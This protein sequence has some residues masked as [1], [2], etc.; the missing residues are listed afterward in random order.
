MFEEVFVR[1]KICLFDIIS[2]KV[3]VCRCHWKWPLCIITFIRRMATLNKY[4]KVRIQTDYMK[5]KEREIKIQKC[6][7]D[8]KMSKNKR[9][10]EEEIE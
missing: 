2:S 8:E 1:G 6:T 7:E 3:F 10:K 5:S 4:G 9:E